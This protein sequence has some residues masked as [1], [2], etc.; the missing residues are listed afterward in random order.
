MSEFLR[1][2][3]VARRCQLPAA[4]VRR[5]IARG[6]LPAVRFTKR[7]VRVPALEFEHWL[8]ERIRS[9]RGEVPR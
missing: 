8:D 4:T 1:V 5:L 9:E 6:E 3:D 2:E 7:F